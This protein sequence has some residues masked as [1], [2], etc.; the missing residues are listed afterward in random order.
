ML[1]NKNIATHLGRY[2]FYVGMLLLFV[3]LLCATKKRIEKLTLQFATTVNGNLSCILRLIF[4]LIF[5]GFKR[6]FCRH[7]KYGQKHDLQ[8]C[9]KR[10]MV[11]TTAEY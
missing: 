5:G 3:F 8:N 6:T 9:N 4:S 2:I 10:L 7:K 1:L 11:M